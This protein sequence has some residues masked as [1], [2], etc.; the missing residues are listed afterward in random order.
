MN[1]VLEFLLCLFLGDTTHPPLGYSGINTARSALSAILTIDQVP[2]GQ[3]PLVK[4]FMKAVFNNRPALPKHTVTWDIDIVL[5]YLRGLSPLKR[6]SRPVLSKKLLVLLLLLSGHRGQTMQLLDIRNMTLTTSKAKFRIGDII[7]TTGPGHH[8]NELSFKAYAP[9]RRLC[10]VRTLT[11]YIA[12]T[13]HIRGD[14]TRLFLSTKKPFA[15]ASRDTLR[16][17]VKDILLAAG[18]DMTIFTP[19][20]TR[21]ASTS[22]AGQFVPLKTIIDTATWSQASTFTKYY[23]KPVLKKTFQDAVLSK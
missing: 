5:Q 18:I 20:S 22:K 14:H 15:P 2:V 10:V 8:V 12:L 7:K 13:K 19:H 4:R 1:D 9:D 16:R 23:Q 6:L 21:A 3:H 11:Q 17:W